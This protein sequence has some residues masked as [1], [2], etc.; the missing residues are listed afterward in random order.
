[1]GKLFDAIKTAAEGVNMRIPTAELNRLVGDASE[2]HTPVDKRG[3]WFKILYTT[4]VRVRPPTFVVFCNSKRGPHFSWERYLVNKF[5]EV[6][7]FWGSPIKV[8]FRN[9]RKTDKHE[10]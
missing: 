4:Q 10:R 6:Y 7:G 9:R 1:V 3:N 8:F 2:K 5:R